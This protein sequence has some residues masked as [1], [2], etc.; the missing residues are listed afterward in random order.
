MTIEEKLENFSKLC[1]D[2][3]QKSAYKILAD[4][5][6]SLE[7]AYNEH[8][9]DANR[10]H[11]MAIRS[12][13]DK[14]HNDQNKELSYCHIKYRK[15]ASDLQKSLKHDL[16]NL[17]RD[18]LNEYKKSDEYVSLLMRYIDNA[19]NIASGEDIDIYIDP[20]DSALLDK[21]SSH[22]HT[23]IKIND[24]SF[25]GGIRAIVPNKNILID[26]SFETKL[27]ELSQSFRFTNRGAIYE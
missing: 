4:Y 8:K 24:V 5:E 3:A 13:K 2:N 15:M 17:V 7:N 10:Q 27:Y 25:G 14:I 26:N 1:E 16:F 12:A 23:D 20:S 19:Y 22:A 11:E 18:K 21:L 6:L 9:V